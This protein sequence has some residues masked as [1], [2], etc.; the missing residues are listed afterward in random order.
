MLLSFIVKFVL[1]LYCK[2][3]KKKQKEAGFGPFKKVITSS[4]CWSVLSIRTFSCVV[5]A[6]D[7]IILDDDNE[8]NMFCIYTEEEKELAEMSIQYTVLGFEPTTFEN[9]S[10]PITTRPGLPPIVA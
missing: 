1:Y 2:K 4:R 6:L 10:P 8:T 5:S 7:S 9:E 3:N